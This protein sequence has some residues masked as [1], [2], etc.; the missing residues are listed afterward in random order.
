[1]FPTKEVWSV[2]QTSEAAVLGGVL[3]TE[4]TKPV[5]WPEAS[6]QFGEASM[7]TS[8]SSS[9]TWPTR[10]SATTLLTDDAMLQYLKAV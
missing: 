2:P 3:E 10:P 8:S 7:K 9:S 5:S 6:F 4:T 1:V